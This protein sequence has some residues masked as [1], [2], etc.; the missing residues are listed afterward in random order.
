[1][2][3]ANPEFQLAPAG[4]EPSP[5]ASSSPSEGPAPHVPLTSDPRYGSEPAERQYTPPNP[6]EP[7]AEGGAQ[8]NQE[9][10]PQVTL[11]SKMYV[12]IRDKPLSHLHCIGCE[13]RA[14]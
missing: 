4:G 12:K 2:P 5:D 14:V 3:G 10:Q 13:T 6:S 8:E 7:A 11:P 9:H 1:M